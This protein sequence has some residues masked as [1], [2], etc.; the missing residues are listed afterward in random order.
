MEAL[1][2][3][4]SSSPLSSPLV[5]EPDAG[6]RQGS[7]DRRLE[8]RRAASAPACRRPALRDHACDEPGRA[9]PM[10]PP[11]FAPRVRE[12]EQDSPYGVLADRTA[13]AGSAVAAA[14]GPNACARRGEQG[15]D[16]RASCAQL[17]RAARDHRDPE[18]VERGPHKDEHICEP[19]SLLLPRIV[20]TETTAGEARQRGHARDQRRAHPRPREAPEFAPIPL[21]GFERV[22]RVWLELRADGLGGGQ[23][24]RR[25]QVSRAARV[26]DV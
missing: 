18:N 22:G 7:R 15:R 2:A 14:R 1:L 9:T 4:G 19:R 21:R 23:G 12:G 5:R 17:G 10:P 24:W 20:L 3:S 13:A 26:R 16:A 25:W 8:L 11:R 6:S